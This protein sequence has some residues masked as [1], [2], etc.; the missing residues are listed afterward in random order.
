MLCPLAS[1]GAIQV[2]LKGRQI[3]GLHRCA[4]QLLEPVQIVQRGNA[5]GQRMSGGQPKANLQYVKNIFNGALAAPLL[6][7]L[8]KA[9]MAASSRA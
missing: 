5:G 8:F 2:P 4:M 1:L 6:K 9:L 3:G 7:T